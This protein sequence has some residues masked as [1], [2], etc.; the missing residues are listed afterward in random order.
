MPHT[1]T[2]YF[3]QLLLIVIWICLFPSD[4]E[5]MEK[6][7][8]SKKQLISNLAIVAGMIPAMTLALLISKHV[9]TMPD[10]N[11]VSFIVLTYMALKTGVL[12]RT[13]KTVNS[14]ST[15]SLKIF[16]H[17][18]E[19]YGYCLGSWGIGYQF[20]DS[21]FKLDPSFISAGFSF[22]LLLSSVLLISLFLN[23]LIHRLYD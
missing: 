14:E 5:N 9:A 2:S 3:L 19:Y 22:L 10:F 20:L 18:V 11:L 6:L 23:K 12:Y 13:P 8:P 4:N 16:F 15:D 1:I 7:I 17:N 21:R